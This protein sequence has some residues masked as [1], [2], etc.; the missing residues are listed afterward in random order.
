[1][2]FKVLGPLEIETDDGPLVV[3]GRRPRALLVAL[4]LQPRVVVS[5]D[6]L[7]DA[8]WGEELPDSP[9]NALQQ[10]VARLRARLGRWA[11]CLGTGPGGYLLSA[12]DD[13]IDAE[14]FER[15]YRGARA[16]IDVDPERAARALEGALSLW[17]GPAYGEFG[18]AFAHVAAVRLEEL[19]LGCQEDRVDLLIRQG[20]TTDAVA[21]ARDLVAAEPLR[22]RRVALL[23]H[24]LHAEGRVAD[25]L[26]AYRNHRSLLAEELGLDPPAT[27]REL[28]SR[29]LADDLPRPPR[30]VPRLASPDRARPPRPDLPRRPG[31]MV[32]R[33]RELELLLD[34]LVSARMVTLVGPGGVGKTR[35]ALEVAHRLAEQGRQVFWVD[36]TVVTPDRLVDALAEGTGV[37]MPRAGS[38]GRDR[39]AG[40]GG[41]RP[42]RS[43]SS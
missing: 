24:A 30:P 27:L 36:L 10:V 18:S 31:A 16:L 34:C 9:A 40:Q 20:L 35:L 25:A 11:A 7:V 23:M 28:E 41:R 38:E 14:L 8:L 29:I 26:D 22:E 19:R 5:T 13:S 2:R 1:M 17:R 15:E 21:Q 12:A 6:R 3:T 42:A 33:E 37:V 39:L 32:G 43:A 4:L